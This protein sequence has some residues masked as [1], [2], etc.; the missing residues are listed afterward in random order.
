MWEDKLNIF[1][2]IFTLS[3]NLKHTY[4][5]YTLTYIV[6]LF[7]FINYIYFYFISQINI[8]IR[9]KIFYSFRNPNWIGKSDLHLNSWYILFIF[10]IKYIHLVSF[11]IETNFLDQI[12]EPYYSNTKHKN[13]SNP[14]LRFDNID[15]AHNFSFTLSKNNKKAKIHP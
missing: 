12:S 4:H 2:T 1:S 7:Y 14:F 9:Q 13:A 15:N 6:N 10:I 3:H 11:Y 8:Q 5:N